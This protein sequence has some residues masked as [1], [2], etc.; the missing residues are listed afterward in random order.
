MTQTSIPYK[1]L[2]KILLKK[3]IERIGSGKG[4]QDLIALKHMEERLIRNATVYTY[5]LKR[6]LI[7]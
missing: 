3:Q 7:R 4:A 6:P 2:A 1:V 5:V